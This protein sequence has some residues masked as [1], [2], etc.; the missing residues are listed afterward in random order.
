M[1]RLTTA[2]TA[3][4]VA[5]AAMVAGLS[6]CGGGPNG[7]EPEAFAR[8][9]CTALYRWMER[10]DV[11]EQRLDATM[12]AAEWPSDGRAA[13]TA[14]V[15]ETVI[16]VEDAEDGLEAVDPTAAGTTS[17]RTPSETLPSSARK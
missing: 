17:R 5:A 14:F 9:L 11:A 7:R 13:W 12:E 1:P 4:A 2:A 16:A 3:A 10:V 6:R 15:R 8:G